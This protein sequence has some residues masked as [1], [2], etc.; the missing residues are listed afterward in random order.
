M[1]EDDLQFFSG[2]PLSKLLLSAG[3]VILLAAPFLVGVYPLTQLTFIVVYTIAGIGLQLLTGFGGQLSLGHGS[4][5]AIG[6]YTCAVMQ[7]HGID[8]SLALPAACV[9]A[10]AVGL[11]AA[12]PA[13]RM[14]GI[15]LL[16]ATIAF[17]FLIEETTARWTSVTGGN[18]GMMVPTAVLFGFELNDLPKLYYVG[19]VLLVCTFLVCENVMRSPIG[20]AMVA[21]RDSEIAATSLGINIRRTKTIAFGMSAGFCAIAGAIIAHLLGFVTPDQFGIDLSVDLLL[22][23]LIG[24]NGSLRGAFLGSVFIIVLPEVLRIVTWATSSNN[25]IVGL[26]PLFEGLVVIAIMRF[27]P[28]G[29]NGLWIKARDASV[30]SL[31]GILPSSARLDK[32]RR[33]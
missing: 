3:L 5:L 2:G 32:E 33:S 7:A 16:T 28:A 10:V 25:E 15:Y 13:L 6:A 17:G 29:L 20:R 12:R 27:E 26:R 14:S 9:L 23:L 24:G 30:R 31:I 18:G 4:F 22:V 8:F 11:I 1:Q 21:V 19:L